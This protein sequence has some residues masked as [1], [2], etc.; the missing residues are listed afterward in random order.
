MVLAIIIWVLTIP[1]IGVDDSNKATIISGL[2]GA[3]TAYLIA[4]AQLTKQL[5]L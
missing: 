3:F 2:A 4:R 1:Y 5:E